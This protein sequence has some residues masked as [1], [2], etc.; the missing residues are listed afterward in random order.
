MQNVALFFFV[1]LH[2]FLSLSSDRCRRAADDVAIA[3]VKV[4]SKLVLQSRA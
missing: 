2:F 1:A 4:D 3:A